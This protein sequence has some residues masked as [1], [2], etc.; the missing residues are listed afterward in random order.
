M[1]LPYCYC[2]LVVS[3]PRLNCVVGMNVAFVVITNI[4]TFKT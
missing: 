2:R 4:N 1:W 3:P